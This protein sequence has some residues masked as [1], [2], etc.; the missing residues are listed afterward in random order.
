[1]ARIGHI[2]A[3]RGSLEV[4]KYWL[5][6]PVIS[7]AGKVSHVVGHTY[8]GLQRV[9]EKIIQTLRRMFLVIQMICE[10]NY[11]QILLKNIFRMVHIRVKHQHLGQKALLIIVW[12]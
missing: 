9:Q 11:T 3:Y 4:I 1:M 6:H 7:F 10:N 8:V 5:W 12:I 2:S